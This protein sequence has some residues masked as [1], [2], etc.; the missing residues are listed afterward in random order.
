MMAL[1]NDRYRRARRLF[2]LLFILSAC[3]LVAFLLF[4]RDS[5][6]GPGDSDSPG[7]LDRILG[8]LG[9]LLTLISTIASLVGL[10]STTYLQWRA[11]RRE[12]K[13]ALLERQHH[14]LEIERLKRQLDQGET[15]QEDD[16]HQTPH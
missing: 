4:S 14:E 9:G 5:E 2:G 12:E 6:P 10:A 1:Q 13:T 3:L 8:D 11:D 7:I 16:D 15:E